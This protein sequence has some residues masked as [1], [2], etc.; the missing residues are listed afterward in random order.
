MLHMKQQL[1]AF[2]VLTERKLL[3]DGWEYVLAWLQTVNEPD[4]RV[5]KDPALY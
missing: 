4:G 1:S 2:V 5:S 3:R